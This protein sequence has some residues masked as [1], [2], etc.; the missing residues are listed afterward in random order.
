MPLNAELLVVEFGTTAHGGFPDLCQPLRAVTGCIHLLAG[1]RNS[2]TPV[3]GF[4][5]THH[6]RQITGDRYVAARQFF[7]SSDARL[8]VIH[9]AELVQIQQLGQLA[10][11]D[12]VVLVPDFRKPAQNQSGC[13]ARSA[14]SSFAASQYSFFP[15]K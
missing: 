2:P 5:A 9:R 10:G 4:Q 15:E 14:I 13:G 7:Q 11:I 12:A 6:P 1:A 8:A 3:D